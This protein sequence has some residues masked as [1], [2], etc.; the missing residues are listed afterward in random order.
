MQ[1]YAKYPQ[2]DGTFRYIPYDGTQYTKEQ[3]D[4]VIAAL[5][6]DQKVA[7][8]SLTEPVLAS[9]FDRWKLRGSVVIVDPNPTNVY[10]YPRTLMGARN[11]F[12]IFALSGKNHL[13]EQYA[14]SPDD[15]APK[16][17]NITGIV[18][19][20]GATL[21]T[22]LVDTPNYGNS[23]PDGFTTPDGYQKK[24]FGG[25]ADQA[26]YKLSDD[27][28]ETPGTGDGGGETEPPT[29]EIG[30]TAEILANSE[31]MPIAIENNGTKWRVRQTGGKAI[32]GMFINGLVK[33]GLGGYDYLPGEQVSILALHDGA[34]PNNTNT[35]TGDKKTFYLITFG[36]I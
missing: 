21:P 34:D 15:G 27:P 3:A 32:V 30:N 13:W 36:D 20:A 17:G 10:G 7:A 28:D 11:G 5:T 2:A 8:T 16:G 29:G 6:Y 14:A 23:P 4:V 31:N 9:G 19:A 33:S 1:A 25:N 26:H 24:Y 12:S 35:W 18:F 22:G